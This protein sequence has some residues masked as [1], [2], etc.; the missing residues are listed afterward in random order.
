M[1]I[2]EQAPGGGFGEKVHTVGEPIEDFTSDQVF[3]LVIMIN[4]L[5][6]CFSASQI[7]ERII[8][9]T[10]PNG[11]L[12]FHDVLIPN[13]AMEVL[14][15]K[16]YDAGH[17][18]RIAEDVILEFLSKNYDELLS[19]HAAIPTDAYTFDSIYFVGRKRAR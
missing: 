5:E 1:H 19:R 18:L 2:Q 3:D 9:L 11:I 6:H 12:V 13:E 4:V 16:I 10:A 14:V 17:P 7:L 15:Q 8:S